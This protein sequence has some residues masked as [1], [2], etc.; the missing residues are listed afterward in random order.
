[1]KKKL[2]NFVGCFRTYLGRY[3][4]GQP[5]QT[6]NLLTY[7]FGGSNPSLPTLNN[8]EFW[9]VTLGAYIQRLKF[10]TQHFFTCFHAGVTQLVESQPSKLL[11][12]GSSPVSRSG[13]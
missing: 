13:F 11:V 6:V 10:K 2:S 4:S 1:M 5:G 8:V 12:A 7:V 3:R 9:M